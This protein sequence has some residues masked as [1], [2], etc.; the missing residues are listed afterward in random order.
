MMT[1]QE[2]KEKTK[3]ILVISNGSKYNATLEDANIYKKGVVERIELINWRN[4]PKDIQAFWKAYEYAKNTLKR[5]DLIKID[6][7]YDEWIKDSTQFEPDKIKVIEKLSEYLDETDDCNTINIE[8][9]DG[10]AI[11]IHHVGDYKE[12]LKILDIDFDIIKI[13]DSDNNS[14]LVLIQEDDKELLKELSYKANGV[15]MEHDRF[16]GDG[17]Y[18]K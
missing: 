6:A 4:Q 14:Q 7:F 2:I 8:N 10:Y 11:G 17:K 3:C 1:L 5:Q 12:T 13:T 18:W 16:I 9:Y 15:A